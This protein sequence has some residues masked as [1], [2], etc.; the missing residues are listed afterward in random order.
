M[1]QMVKANG[2]SANCGL[3]L[4]SGG[5]LALMITINSTLAG[6]SSPVLASWLAH[7]VGTLVALLL[8]LLLQGFTAFGSST[9]SGSVAPLWAYLAGVPGAFT[10]VLA[11]ITVNSSLGL[12]ASIGL[13]M[14]GQVGFS[15]I[16]DRLGLFGLSKKPFSSNDG[17]AISLIIIGIAVMLAGKIK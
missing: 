10:V 5:L 7:G 14:A 8:L 2:D 17:V 6:Y 15:L 13:I 4:F 11:A 1:T 3:A 12:S 16:S 9:G